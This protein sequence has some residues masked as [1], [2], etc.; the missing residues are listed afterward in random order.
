MI[1]FFIYRNAQKNYHK[2]IN[3]YIIYVLVELDIKFLDFF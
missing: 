1:R 2:D 3:F